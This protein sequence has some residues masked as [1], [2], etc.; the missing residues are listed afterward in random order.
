M[1]ENRR[2]VHGEYDT[3]EYGEQ[4]ERLRAGHED[5]Y[6]AQSTVSKDQTNTPK[7]NTQKI[8]RGMV[9]VLNSLRLC[10]DTGLVCV[11]RCCTKKSAAADFLVVTR[12]FPR[13]N[14]GG[15]SQS[16]VSE[17]VKAHQRAMLRTPWWSVIEVTSQVTCRQCNI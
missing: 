12:M 6:I 9:C 14:L 17:P 15:C 4:W 11:W 1:K 16:R 3:D 2:D 5:D 8:K 10:L 13:T 7:H